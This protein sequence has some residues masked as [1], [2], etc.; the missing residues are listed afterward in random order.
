MSKVGNKLYSYSVTNEMVHV[1]RNRKP[2]IL[3]FFSSLFSRQGII[4]CAPKMATGKEAFRRK[5]L[6]RR[7]IKR[8]GSRGFMFQPPSPPPPMKDDL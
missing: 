7:K 6:K 5:S 3:H 2:C 1:F 8:S 4:D